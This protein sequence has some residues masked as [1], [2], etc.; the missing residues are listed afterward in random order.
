MSQDDSDAG[1]SRPAHRPSTE[2]A[3]EEQAK[4]L[5]RAHEVAQLG[6]FVID[7]ATQ[8]ITMSPELA[9]MYAVGD[10]ATEMGLDEYRTRFYHP[11]DRVRGAARA[12]A[13]YR[14][15]GDLTL[16][17]RV[18][19]G[20]GEVIWVRAR[21]SVEQPSVDDSRVVGVVQDI[22]DYKQAELE[23]RRAYEV[24]RDSELK[25]RT[26]FQDSRDAIWITDPRGRFLDV[27]QAMLDLYGYSRHELRSL[28]AHDLYA[29]PRCASASSR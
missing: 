27:N 2:L 8:R 20:D 25:Y 15:R 9:A 1:G 17:S 26:L 22:T 14:E 12:N 7:L 6:Y 3:F 28:T 4:L 16:E 23:L 24:V 19:R 13:A 18:I 11:D 5:R 21:S 10:E 29:E